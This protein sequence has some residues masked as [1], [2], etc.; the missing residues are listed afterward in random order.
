MPIYSNN[1][2]GSMALAQVAANE[3]YTSE[4]F[5]RIMYESQL[6]DMAF[7]EAVLACDFKEIKGLREGTI[8]EAEVAALNERS[9]KEL[10]STA[11]EGLKKFW[12]KLKGAFQDAINKIGSWIGNNG[13]ALAK[14]VNAAN[15]DAW[16]G[17][18]EGVLTYNHEDPVVSNTL[19]NNITNDLFKAVGETDINVASIVGGYLGRKLGE[20]SVT[21][22]DYT[23]KV[24]DKAKS[25]IIVDKSNVRDV[26]KQINDGK[27]FIGAVKGYQKAAEDQINASIK[28]LKNIAEKEGNAAKLNG[29]VHAYQTIV[30]TVCKANIAVIRA[31]MKSKA[32]AVTRAL[33]DMRKMN[34]SVDMEV[35]CVMDAFDEAMTGTLNID[36]NTKAAVAELV[37][38]C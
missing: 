10:V 17:K 22:R 24:F 9:L 12:A 3:S 18:I 35:M 14:Q 28:D 32:A 1:R 16:T 25:V 4:D 2:T 23:K 27:F 21:P 15:V 20:G 8:L 13:K 31:D 33:A 38:A 5:G 19:K 7:F 26:A 29:I 37:A 34:E 11:I 36:A 30:A 6:N